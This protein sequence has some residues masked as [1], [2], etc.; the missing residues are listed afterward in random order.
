[1]RLFGS[2]NV[3]FGGFDNTYSASQ[4]AFTFYDT[5]GLP[6]PQGAI[7]VDEASAFHA[8]FSNT[9]AGGMFQVLAQFHV[10][11]NTALIGFVTAQITNSQGTSTAQ[12]IPFGN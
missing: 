12:K 2:L 1:V 9:T 4:I 6:L 3:S 10:T 8:Y 5:S 11:G 7:G